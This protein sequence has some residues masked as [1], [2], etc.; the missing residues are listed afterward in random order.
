MVQLG[1]HN[2]AFGNSWLE[3]HGGVSK[4]YGVD[5]D[6][7]FTERVYQIANEGVE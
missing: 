4:P 2:H 5:V 7:T 6:V 3:A 1:K